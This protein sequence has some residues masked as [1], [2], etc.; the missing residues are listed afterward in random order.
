MV[1]VEIKINSMKIIIKVLLETIL[2]GCS[3]PN[4][5]NGQD[6]DQPIETN[7]E[8][9][10]VHE[11]DITCEDSLVLSYSR[12]MI[13]PNK[14]DLELNNGHLIKWMKN[15]DSSSIQCFSFEG[16]D[17][18]NIFKS[19]RLDATGLMANFYSY[20]ILQKGKPVELNSLSNDIRLFALNEE[21]E[22]E[23]YL[24]DYS[25]EFLKTRDWD[26]VFLKI[27]KYK[28]NNET[29]IMINQFNRQCN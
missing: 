12:A 10:N 3:N 2:L 13:L 19:V 22:L 18:I 24:F 6:L 14:R 26:N 27:T 17:A 7:I 5:S 16:N 20:L 11:E 21:M 4:L 9:N 25:E 23:Y 1:E 15:I 8:T 29:P 28:L